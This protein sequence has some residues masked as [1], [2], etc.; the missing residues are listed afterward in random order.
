MRWYWEAGHFKKEL[1]DLVLDKLFD[2]SNRESTVPV[3]FGVLLTPSNIEARLADIRV[4]RE[5]YAESHRQE[6]ADLDRLVASSINGFAK[7]R[8]L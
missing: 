4:E 2:Y 1:G 7:G 3:G 6:V 5:R 8:K